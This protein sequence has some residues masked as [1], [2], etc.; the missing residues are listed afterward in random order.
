MTRIV[1]KARKK[2]SV[3]PKDIDNYF[4]IVGKDQKYVIIGPDNLILDSKLTIHKKIKIE[5]VMSDIASELK[6]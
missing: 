1:K 4:Y 6:N 3:F 5:D 2:R